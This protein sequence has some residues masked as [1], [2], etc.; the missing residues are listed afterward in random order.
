MYSGGIPVLSLS[1]HASGVETHN[2]IGKLNIKNKK[3]VMSVKALWQIRPL[4]AMS[5]TAGM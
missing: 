4:C 2:R 3:H 5:V 1:M